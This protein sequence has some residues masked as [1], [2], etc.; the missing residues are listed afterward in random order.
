MPRPPSDIW[1]HFTTFDDPSNKV[2]RARCNYCDHQ[3]ASSISRLQ[4]HITRNCPSVPDIV[5]QEVNSRSAGRFKNIVPFVTYDTGPSTD[6]D[7][8]LQVLARASYNLPATSSAVPTTR[9]MNMNA[10]PAGK[11]DNI[12]KNSLDWQLA[13][14]LFSADI[15]LKVIEN[16]HIIQ[17]LKRLN[18]NYQVPDRRQLQQVLLKREHWDL[19]ADRRVDTSNAND[20]ASV[21]SQSESEAVS[22]E[23]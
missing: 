12:T 19:L 21:D 5:R 8:A 15:S 18:P 4:R 2:K 7:D 17:F 1:H 23:T 9:T 3:Q 6:L 22:M 10:P 11:I 14:A 20:A 13:R 16:P